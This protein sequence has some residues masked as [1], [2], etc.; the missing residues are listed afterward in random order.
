MTG[1]T[2]PQQTVLGGR[3]YG[4]H[5]DFRDILEIF[6]YLESPD[7]P[8]FFRWQVALA[9]FYK[10]PLEP[11]HF[12][13]G[14]AYFSWFVGGGQPEE[15]TVAPKLLDWEKDAPLIVADINKVA[16]QEIRSLPYVHWWTFLSWF[17]SIGDGQLS[18]LLSIRAKRQRGEKL[19]KWE[20][21]YY[22]RNK[23]KVDL[24]QPVSEAQRA[25]KDRLMAQLGWVKER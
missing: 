16:G 22:R 8:D 11:A 24:P 25:E 18:T 14:A 12:Q 9:L 3:K 15:S 17:H 23:A 20:K 13:E 6:S 1:F 2:L 5:T 10:E 7:W 4:L 21:E 19:E